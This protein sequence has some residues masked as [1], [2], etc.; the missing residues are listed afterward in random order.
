LFDVIEN[1]HVPEPEHAPVQPAKE[2]P[3]AASPVRVTGEFSATLIV[4]V[5]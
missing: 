4:H 1:V 2:E 5:P 3:V